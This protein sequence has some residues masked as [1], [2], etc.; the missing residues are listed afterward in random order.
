MVEASWEEAKVEEVE[1]VAKLVEVFEDE[2]S[3]Q[4][5]QDKTDVELNFIER[6]KI[7][8][9]QFNLSDETSMPTE[10]SH[11]KLKANKPNMMDVSRLDGYDSEKAI[12]YDPKKRGKREK[13]FCEQCNKI[14]VMFDLEKHMKKMHTAKVKMP[15][16]RRKLVNCKVCDQT[17]RDGWNLTRHMGSMHSVQGEIN[18]PKDFCDSTFESEYDMKVKTERLKNYFNL[19]AGASNTLSV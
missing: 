16:K 2:S 17:V 9:K 1:E 4:L 12:I 14:L 15:E 13:V 18:C 3:L 19:K 7:W 11:K 8:L 5:Q 10:D 6:K